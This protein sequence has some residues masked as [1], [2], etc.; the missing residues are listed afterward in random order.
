MHTAHDILKYL[1]RPK[2]VLITSHR[3]PDG[4]AVGSCL[5][6]R[7]A[8]LTKFH[9]VRIVLP[10]EFP[11]DLNWM[12]GAD[13]IVIYDKTPE[14]ALD[15]VKMSELVFCLDFNSLERIDKVGDAIRNSAMPAVMIDHHLY[16]ESFAEV[17]ISRPEMSSTC[18]LLYE[19]FKELGWAHDLKIPC[20]EALLTGI[21]TDT[22]SFKY[23]V[24]P[25]TFA[26]VSK[27]T[28]MGGDIA[29]VQDQLFNHLKE[30]NLRLLGHCLYN[31]MTL[32]PDSKAG[33]IYLSKQDYIDFNI[34]RGDTEGI[35]N[36]LL[37]LHD[38]Y[39]AAFITEQPNIVKIS[40]RS[41]GNFSVEKMSKEYFRGGGHKN[42]SG[43]AINGSLRKAI[44]LFTDAVEKYKQEIINSY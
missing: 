4:D 19:V 24:N 30:K 36:H 16:P 21:I 20:L 18:E 13:E 27:L 42:A 7:S 8:L 2:N 12:E 40:L 17:A 28:A 32:I 22:G 33:Y 41:K 37:R 23:N 5:A 6:L 14:Q 3:N 10:S 31:R 39:V 44:D 34:L 1:E 38:V 15:Y 26:N 43:G 35:V 25:D 11:D 9:T 29:F